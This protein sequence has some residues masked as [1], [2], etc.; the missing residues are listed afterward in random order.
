M[1]D[2]FY[3]TSE[4]FYDTCALL[5]EDLAKLNF[6]FYISYYTLIELE[7]IKNSEEKNPQIR[8]EARKVLRFLYKNEGKYYI[9]YPMPEEE[10]QK[11]IYEK[12][13][14]DTVD[15]RILLSALNLPIIF[16][17]ADLNCYFLAKHYFNLN[18][19]YLD[20]SVKED[21]Y[22]GYEIVSYKDEDQLADLYEKIYSGKDY[23]NIKNNQYLFIQDS[24]KK[25]IDS[26]KQTDEGL[27]RLPDFL[28]FESKMFGKTKARDPY[29]LAVMDSLLNNKIT[30]I[31]G[32]A[33]A[34][35][36]YLSL[37]YLFDK[38]EHGK[39]NKIVIFCN[40]V[41]TAGSAKLGYY[42]GSREEKLLDSQIG[43]FLSSKMGDRAGV[44]QLIDQ[45]SLI[46]LP[47]SDIRGYD[48][49]GM[50]A[51][52]Y[53]TEAQNLNIDLMKLALQRIGEDSICILDG[54]SNTQVDLNIYAGSNNG[55]KRVSEVFRGQDFYG[56]VTLPN[57]YRSKIAKIAQKM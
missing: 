28:C 7:N 46:L 44:E 11:W 48:T 53:I 9:S 47:M 52:V 20:V 24:N 26:Y 21:E 8:Y 2:S 19:K 38:L 27:I 37:A 50:N 36:S 56:E 30:M 31:R 39:I 32:A 25:I 17:T 55:M 51:G 4:F 54:D 35:K 13:A 22:K 29:Q 34:G 3:D 42:P 10:I 43:N 15:T 5:N 23:F 33:G 6:P 41:A 14:P 12:K 16:E 18:T 40:T 49:T 45:G 57:I 1:T